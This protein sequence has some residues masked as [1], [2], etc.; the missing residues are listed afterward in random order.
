MNRHATA[1]GSIVGVV[2]AVPARVITNAD[3]PDPEAADE[4]AKLTGVR[5]RRWVATGQSA[6]TLCTDAAKR[7]LE[8]LAWKPASIDVLVYVTQTPDGA[9]PADVYRIAADLGL[10]VS[11]ACLQINWSCAGYVYGL[12]TT[13]RLL[14]SGKRALLLVGD[15]T[16]TIADPGDRATAPLFGDAASATAI[17]GSSVEQ[18]FVLGTDGAGADKLC[19]DLRASRIRLE[20][21]PFLEMDGAAVFN[22]TLREVPKLVADLRTIMPDAH[23]H[24]MHQ[25]N[26]F[27]LKH[28]VRKCGLAPA[29]TPIN[30]QR[31]GNCSSASIPL[32]MCDALSLVLTK[33]ASKEAPLKLA[34]LGYGAGWAYAGGAIRCEHILGVCELIEV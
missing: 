15:A 5:E 17:E 21:G 7:L 6:R 29:Y 2:A 11:C 30:I 12:W 31:F 34:L 22:F 18:H 32:L 3:C 9:V 25:A 13:M 19:Q 10:P 16:S 26:E 23:W 27:I 24:L 1:R 20:D 14:D 33:H 28:L 4:A 8:G